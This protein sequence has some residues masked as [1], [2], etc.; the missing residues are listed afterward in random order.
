MERKNGYVHLVTWNERSVEFSGV[1]ARKLATTMLNPSHGSRVS[2]LPLLTP[3]K[4]LYG[5]CLCSL[6]CRR[7]APPWVPFFLHGL[8]LCSR[9]SYLRPSTTPYESVWLIAMRQ[10]TVRARG[11]SCHWPIERQ[12]R[13]ATQS[14]LWGNSEMFVLVVFLKIVPGPFVI[15]ACRVILVN[16][17]L[18]G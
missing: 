5:L 2:P 14:I 13:K 6:Y 18:G 3:S 1:R 11:A 4:F 10:N 16:I 8:C 7:A 17:G 9:R 15:F 12:L